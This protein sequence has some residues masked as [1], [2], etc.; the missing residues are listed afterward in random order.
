MEIN[1]SKFKRVDL[2]SY[3]NRQMTTASPSARRWLPDDGIFAR[4]DSGMRA[5]QTQTSPLSH[6][7]KKNA[8]NTKK[9]K[10]IKIKSNWRSGSRFVAGWGWSWASWMSCP[11]AS[12]VWSRTRVTGGLRDST[13]SAKRNGRTNATENAS[14]PTI[15]RS[16]SCDNLITLPTCTHSHTHRRTHTHTHTSANNFPARPITFTIINPPPPFNLGSTESCGL[17]CK[18][19]PLLLSSTA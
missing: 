6:L 11:E 8:S 18:F 7:K 2:P 17:K 5:E 3:W 4:F 10:D 1:P 12:H 15:S 16:I 14:I 13:G 19:D 9:K